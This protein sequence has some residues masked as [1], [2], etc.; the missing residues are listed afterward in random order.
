MLFDI[1]SG[2]HDFMAAA[3]APHFKIGSD[4]Q[5]LPTQ[6]PAGVLFFHR[7]YIADTDVHVICLHPVLLL[8]LL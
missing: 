2:A 8:I 7:Q 6:R 1:A 5:H 4:P 3:G